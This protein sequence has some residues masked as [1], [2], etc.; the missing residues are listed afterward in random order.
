LFTID[1]CTQPSQDAFE[2]EAGDKPIVWG[3]AVIQAAFYDGQ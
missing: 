3:E 2:D 1:I